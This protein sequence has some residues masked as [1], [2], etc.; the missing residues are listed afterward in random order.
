MDKT[1][2]KAAEEFAVH[3]ATTKAAGDAYVDART[4]YEGLENERREK[5][6]AMMDLIPE[7]EQEVYIAVDAATMVKVNRNGVVS[8]H[9][10]V[11]L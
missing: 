4:T 1:L 9:P 11:T 6:R 5:A 2:A 3:A 8:V 10:F 7:G